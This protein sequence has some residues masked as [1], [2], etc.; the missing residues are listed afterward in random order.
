MVKDSYFALVMS[1]KFS[2]AEEKK[3]FLALFALKFAGLTEYVKEDSST[4]ETPELRLEFQLAHYEILEAKVEVTLD[5][6]T[7]YSVSDLSE[8]CNVQL[9]DYG[10]NDDSPELE[11]EASNGK[12]TKYECY[13]WTEHDVSNFNLHA[14]KDA[15]P[16]LV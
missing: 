10:Q 14:E 2:G 4:K 7:Y 11:I 8:G 16:G 5:G 12:I 9:L 1:Q 3:A 6:D 13:E 15:S